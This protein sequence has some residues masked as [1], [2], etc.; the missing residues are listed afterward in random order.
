[1]DVNIK[2]LKSTGFCAGV[3]T[4][5]KI[6]DNTFKEQQ[7]IVLLGTIIHNEYVMNKYENL[8][9]FVVEPTIESVKKFKSHCFIIPAHGV[10][11][12]VYDY[13]NMNNIFYIDA[14]CKI[15]KKIKDL[16]IKKSLTKPILILGDTK[17][18]E[19][20]NIKSFVPSVKITDNLNLYQDIKNHFIFCQS[21]FPK[22]LFNNELRKLNNR[23]SNIIVNTSC[24]LV[25]KRLKELSKYLDG[26][27]Y[28]IVGSKSSFN[29]NMQLKF[30]T[31]QNKNAYLISTISDLENIRFNTVSSIYISSGTSTSQDTVIEVHNYICK[32]FASIKNE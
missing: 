21:T 31:M 7:N 11:K 4:T 23:N 32:K 1:M 6:L 10:K 16:A 17:H 22:Y 26:D 14:T 9:V 12:D 18:K 3:M 28:L 13:L 24:P 19:C 29:T 20:I 8:G 15:V 30:L 27:I 5:L 2:I 25:E